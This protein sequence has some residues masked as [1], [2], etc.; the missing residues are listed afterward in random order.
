MKKE[1]SK[2]G[3][4]LR[5]FSDRQ[6]SMRTM[7][8]TGGMSIGWGAAVGAEVSLFVHNVESREVGL[9]L[10]RL[11]YSALCQRTDEQ[12]R[13][14]MFPTPKLPRAPRATKSKSSPPWAAV[15]GRPRSLCTDEL[16]LSRQGSN[17]PSR[18]RRA[19]GRG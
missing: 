14:S 15:G 1:Y 4:A 8:T 7:W 11:A 16:R 2:V 17:R 19:K 5:H 3:A 6:S 13:A 18:A 9:P 12:G 10:R